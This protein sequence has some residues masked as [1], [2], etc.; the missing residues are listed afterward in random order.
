VT[1]KVV[2]ILDKEYTRYYPKEHEIP[3]YERPVL[4]RA[5]L[6]YLPQTVKQIKEFWE[7]FTWARK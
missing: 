3:Y 1:Y 2:A 7:D 6:R 5:Q 4:L